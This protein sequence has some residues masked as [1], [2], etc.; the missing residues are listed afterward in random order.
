MS[1]VVDDDDVDVDDGSSGSSSDVVVIRDSDDESA[2]TSE[3]ED[4]GKLQQQRRRDHLD[5]D[6]D[7]DLL[8][9]RAIDDGG[10]QD[11][12]MYHLNDAENNNNT[13]KNSDRFDTWCF[14]ARSYRNPLLKMQQTQ[15]QSNKKAKSKGK[16]KRYGSRARSMKLERDGLK[17]LRPLLEKFGGQVDLKNPQMKIYLMDGLV[18]L[19]D[20][21]T[22]SNDPQRQ[23]VVGGGMMGGGMG[24]KKIPPQKKKKKATL[25]VRQIA[26]G[27]RTSIISPA[28]RICVTTTPLEEIAAFCLVNVAQ[29]QPYQ[30]ILDPYSGSCTTFLAAAMIVEHQQQQQQLENN[31]NKKKKMQQTDDDDDDT[32]ATIDTQR[33]L[34]EM[35]GIEVANEWYVNRT[36]IMKDFE[37][38][39]FARTRPTKLIQGDCTSLQI[40]HEALD[41]LLQEKHN[42]NDNNAT[43]ETGDRPPLSFDV[44]ITDPPYGIREKVE[45]SASSSSSTTT[46][47]EEAEATVGKTENNSNNNN[48]KKRQMLRRQ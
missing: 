41:A 44:I 30:R 26:R 32:A 47:L 25:L 2:S 33:P 35:V 4:F 34:L 16:G 31:S 11:M 3:E 7:L 5:F 37:S 24:T 40:R 23:R 28:S 36:N 45:S 21:A 17:A 18:P 12:Y 10:F 14:R 38:R 39:G 43:P 22:T 29:V 19:N 13:D 8:A 9:Q 42:G 1:Q 27:P 48:K 15:Q 46:T 20:A 6:L